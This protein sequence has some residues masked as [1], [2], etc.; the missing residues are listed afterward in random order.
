MLKESLRDI[1]RAANRQQA[2]Q[3]LEA[4]YQ[5]VGDYD[6]PELTRLDGTLR[7]RQPQLLAYF[8]SRLSNGP[9]EGRNLVIKHVKRTGY[10]FRNFHNYRI[11]VLHRCA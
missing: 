6:L 7:R 3:E 8:D 5:L 1:Y 10:G 4:W 11:T 2:E 9:T